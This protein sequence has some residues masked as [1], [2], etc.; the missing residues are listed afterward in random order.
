MTFKV[1]EK[2]GIPWLSVTRG[3]GTIVQTAAK[4]PEPP[5]VPLA[6]ITTVADKEVQKELRR[7][8]IRVIAVDEAQI[9]DPNKDSGWGEFLP[10]K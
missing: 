1:L 6:S 3:K 9:A 4:M 7:M 8:Q 10:Y 5:R 2:W